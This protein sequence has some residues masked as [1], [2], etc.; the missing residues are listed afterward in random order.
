MERIYWLIRCLKSLLGTPTLARAKS[1]ADLAAESAFSGNV[2]KCQRMSAYESV[3]CVWIPYEYVKYV[4][5]SSGIRQDVHIRCRYVRH[6]LEVRYSYAINTLTVRYI[7]MPTYDNICPPYS[8]RYQYASCTVLYGTV[9]YCTVAVRYIFMPTY[10][11]VCPP[12]S[13]RYQYA[14]CTVLYGTVR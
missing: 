4:T 2:Y 3:L 1:K 11:N 8:I 12:Y 13:I 7:F 9:R 5:Q 14:S 6:T 10:G